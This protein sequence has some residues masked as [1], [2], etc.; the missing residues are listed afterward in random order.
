M[1]RQ[2]NGIEY[3]LTFKRI[4]NVN[5]RITPDGEIKV[6]APYRTDADFIDSF[7]ASRRSFIENAKKKTDAKTPVPDIAVANEAVYARLYQIMREV[8]TRFDRYDFRLPRL[9]IRKMKSQWGNCRKAQG[10]VT[11][12]SYLY[13]LPKAYIEFVCA[14][15]LSHMVEANHSPRFY[16]VLESVMPDWRA[17]EAGLKGYRLVG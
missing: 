8:Y 3:D 10:I 13:P 12:N 4:K 15:E 2:I 16:A 6:S 1:K 7:V 5:L 14:H 9:R 11:L 17:R